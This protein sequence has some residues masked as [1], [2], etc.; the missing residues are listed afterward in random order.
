MS[1]NITIKSKLWINYGVMA[2]GVFAICLATV[3][4]MQHFKD[5]LHNLLYVTGRQNLNYKETQ[6]HLS[7]LE[8]YFHIL[9]AAMDVKAIEAVDA[10][11]QKALASLEA[12]LVSMNSIARVPT[13]IMEGGKVF[14]ELFVKVKSLKTA[15][16]EL[17]EDKRRLLRTISLTIAKNKGA[18]ATILDNNE[19]SIFLAEEKLKA[20]SSNIQSQIHN[21]LHR[22]F[23]PFK[24]CLD[25]I[26]YLDELEISATRSTGIDDPDYLEPLRERISAAFQPVAGHLATLNELLGDE[27]KLLLLPVLESMECLETMLLG[28]SGLLALQNRVV[29]AR[30]EYGLVLEIATRKIVA[31]G[32]E[33]EEAAES[34]DLDA[35]SM[36]DTTIRT[37]SGIVTFIFFVFLGL[38]LLGGCLSL[39]VIRS[40][41]RP[42]DKGITF[43]QAIAA[44]NLA[45]TLELTQDDEIGHLGHALNNMA[46]TLRLQDWRRTGRAFLN[47]GIRGE[48]AVEALADTVLA[49]VAQYLGAQVG[50]LYVRDADD[51]LFRR[52]A[53][54]AVAHPEAL[55]DAFAF[56]QGLAGRAALDKQALLLDDLPEDYLAVGSGLGHTAPRHILAVPLVAGNTVRAIV[57]LGALKPFAPQH[58]L[59]LDQI[60]ESVAIA[61]ETAQSRDRVRH[62]LQHTQE[63]AARLEKQQHELQSKNNALEAQTAALRESEATLQQQQEELRVTNEE[64]E[65]QTRA[66]KEYQSTLQAQQEELRVANEEL[67]ERTRETEHQ[68]DAMLKKNVE[69]V[70][71]QIEIERKAREVELASRYK[72]QFMANMSHELRTPLNSILILSQVM[73]ANKDGNLNDR[74]LEY[75]KTIKTSGADLLALINEILDLAKVEAGKMEARPEDLRLAELTEGL[76]RI[77]QPVAAKKGLMLSMDIAENVPEIIRAD[78][79]RLQQV[80]R[81]LLSNA[82]KFTE[83]GGVSLHIHRPGPEVQLHA[84]GLTRENAIAFAVTDTGVGIPED[85][86]ALIFEAFQQADGSTSRKYGGTGLGL[87]IA[88]EMAR[89]LGG[90]IQLH[91]RIDSGSC[92]TMLLAA[93]NTVAVAAEPPQALPPASPVPETL[94]GLVPPQLDTPPALL[95]D[96]PAAFSFDDK[97][98]EAGFVPDD[99]RSLRKGERSLLIIGDDAALCEKLR[100][101]AHERGFKTL[102]AENGET[103]LHFA[104]FYCPSAIILDLALAGTDGWQ[105]MERL[106]ESSETRHIP[107]H[108]LAATD[109]QATGK[110]MGALG[111]LKKTLNPEE[112]DN[113]FK[114]IED[115]VS[116]PVKRLLLVEDNDIQRKSIIELVA[117]PNV[118]TTAVATGEEAYA[119]L[120]RV[121][122]DCMILDLGL[123]GD[124]NGFELLAQVRDDDSIPKLPI[125]IYTGRDLSKQEESQLFRYAESII[126]KGAHS[127]ERLLD[128]ATLFL[129][130]VESDLPKEKQRALRMVYDKEAAFKGKK[131]L[132][133]DDDMRNLFALASALEEKGMQVLE[134]ADG[135]EGLDRLRTHDDIDLVLMD[136]MMPEMD[137]YETIKQIR[138]MKRYSQVPIISLTA[139]AMKGDRAKCIEAGANDYLA[140]PV[141]LVKLLSLLRVWLHK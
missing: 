141:D 129:H 12:S 99:R 82:M 108:F 1:V 36:G 83:K 33:A 6:F 26:N 58:R 89:I 57:E 137:G 92:F 100:D 19:L 76:Y 94:S 70:Q 116:R 93:Q 3:L 18:L 136:T 62:L 66:L 127:P 32:I 11:F 14:N 55:P 135:N 39:F 140:K 124:Q 73:A 130:H 71:A 37:L 65:E 122:F 17:E 41:V 138:G 72:S 118:K 22:N 107:V 51:A 43:A 139:K 101:I 59:F 61:I 103:G 28:E 87:S 117:D 86:Q 16:I 120:R 47:D 63:Q 113:A 30:I 97:I 125:I 53:T 88:R 90:E 69:L 67:A 5:I 115:I 48:Q 7:Q 38:L 50:V 54:Y 49:F 35:K 31:V 85:K 79:Q 96:A 46:E 8:G 77:F 110:K 121:P 44:G 24:N 105:V 91:S 123:G 134:A 34:I 68:R 2:L 111:F 20:S 29:Q 132:L 84:P 25:I 112:L 131:I 75:A 56:G 133:V 4:Q 23:G 114:R 126:I 52:I 80:L 60:E 40:I 81:N 74:Q 98:N 10:D 42:L 78:G 109:M 102:I 64:L 128:E 15:N 119:L 95:P 106:K 45:A 27:D 13:A 104:D 21:L 9:R